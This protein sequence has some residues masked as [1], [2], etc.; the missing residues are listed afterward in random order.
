[1]HLKE[2]KKKKERIYANPKRF[3]EKQEKTQLAAPT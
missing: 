3:F 1:M 2:K